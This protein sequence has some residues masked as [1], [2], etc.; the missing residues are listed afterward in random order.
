MTLV[1]HLTELRDRLIKIVVAVVLGMV[2]A[3]LLYDPIFNFLLE[4]YEH[5]ANSKSSLTGGRLLQVDPLEGFS[6]R[7]K[8]AAYGGIGFAMPVIL[9]Q[10][11]RFVTPGL[12]PQREALRRPVPRRARCCCS[13]SAPGWRTTRCRGRWTS[14]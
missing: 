13:C 14:W 5:I 12:Y 11:W 6:I 2:V 1:E 10:V 7:M 9:W 4:P 8:L 3:F